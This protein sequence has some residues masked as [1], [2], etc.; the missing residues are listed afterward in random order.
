[1][2]KLIKGATAVLLLLA[3]GA[4]L[5]MGLQAREATGPTTARAA[6]STPTLRPTATARHR[7]PRPRP[8]ASTTATATP[9]GT[10]AP[11]AP[12][13]E[14]CD[15]NIRARTPTTSCPF[16]ENVFYAYYRETAGYGGAA[17]VQAWS[18]ITRRTYRLEC[19]AAVVCASADGAEVRFP[20]AAVEAYD[21]D[22]ADA[23]ARTHDVGPDAAPDDE[24][25]G[26]GSG[27][28]PNPSN[29]IPNY[30]EGNGYPV[31]CSDGMWSRSGGLQGA[32]SGHGGVG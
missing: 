7:R 4:F 28:G 10:P 9:A 14:F 8:R 15:T 13:F 3:I 19:T 12:A 30:D 1:M 22:Q 2:T 31:R 24:T 17:S 27:E 25:Q 32:C 6:A 5:G 29:E 23:Y 26:L 11:P 20:A 18:P 21:A 16:A